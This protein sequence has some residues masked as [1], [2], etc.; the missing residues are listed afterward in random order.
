MVVN[1]LWRSHS[2]LRASQEMLWIWV[3]IHRRSAESRHY[4]LLIAIS[5]SSA[6]PIGRCRSL[7]EP[8]AMIG[9][10]RRAAVGSAWTE[11]SINLPRK[12]TQSALDVSEKTNVFLWH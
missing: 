2:C 4:G 12:T 5:Y 8:L 11:H 1:Y 7:I 6:I 9:L 10:R 3:E